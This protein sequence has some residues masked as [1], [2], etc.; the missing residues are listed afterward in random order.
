[1]RS[2]PSC[3]TRTGKKRST[4][5]TQFPANTNGV[6]TAADRC[7]MRQANI[8]WR[9]VIASATAPSAQQV[10]PQGMRGGG[11]MGGGRGGGR[12]AVLTLLYHLGAGKY[13]STSPATSESV[14]KDCPSNSFSPEGSDAEQDCVCNAGATGPN[15]ATCDLCQVSQMSPDEPR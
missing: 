5:G 11:R 1:M 8:R 4:R 7:G 6:L 2:C 9:S 12:G 3:G 13:S 10:L 14:C 15:G